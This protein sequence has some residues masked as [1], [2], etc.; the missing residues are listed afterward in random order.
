M[1]DRLPN[2]NLLEAGLELMRKNGKPLTKVA[3]TGR[4]MIYQLSNREQ[5]RV[6]TCND[7]L[8]IVLA[9]SP[10]EDAK[11]N[12]EGTEWLLIVMPEEERSPGNAFAY[13]VPTDVAVKTVRE[14]HKAWLNTNP[15]TKGGNTTWNIWFGTDGT[16]KP[17]NNFKEKWRQYRL[18]GVAT[19]GHAVVL[20][21]NGDAGDV[22]SEVESAR[23]R[24]S[25]AAGVVPEAVKIS[26]DFGD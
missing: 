2:E 11:L 16:E 13:F 3:G 9:K 17:H 23:Q 15:D 1:A 24:I 14:S 8:L 18:A 20:A 6:R 4:S 10:T 7:H 22:K 5:V 25:R 26:I 21:S 19:V 12:I